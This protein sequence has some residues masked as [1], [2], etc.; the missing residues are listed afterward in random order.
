MQAL[1]TFELPQLLLKVIL[2]AAALLGILLVCV[3]LV[4]AVLRLLRVRG[5][6]EHPILLTNQGNA[7]SVYHLTVESQEPRLSFRFFMN[8]IPL[9]EVP[10]PA[11]TPPPPAAQPTPVE[12][13]APQ[14]GVP[15][16][17]ASQKSATPAASTAGSAAKNA[18]K[19]GQGVAKKTG[20]LASLLGALGGLLPGKAGQQLKER[21]NQAREMQTKT[22]Q[23]MEAPESAQRRM[24]AVQK[25][26][27]QLGVQTPA[28]SSPAAGGRSSAAASPIASASASAAANAP[29][30]GMSASRQSAVQAPAHAL[31][32]VYTAQTREVTPGETISLMLR[33]GNHQNFA[34]LQSCFCE[35][36][37]KR[38]QLI[39]IF[40]QQ[41][42]K[43]LI[44]T[45]QGVKIMVSFV[46]KN[47]RSLVELVSGIFNNW[48]VSGIGNLLGADILN[49][50]ESC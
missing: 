13:S 36:L 29:Q 6:R 24:D 46:N 19:A 12:Q 39:A 18:K 9:A 8:K 14:T 7:R 11:P 38:F 16:P 50:K 33:I 43:C 37:L 40:L 41:F 4:V 48:I 25:S 1:I 31:P 35:I 23:A 15:A 47:D 44:A 28:G 27:G 34:L 10:P 45:A 20:A 2:T 17:S 26:S 22:T 49:N 21:G 5:A 3:L 30:A 42:C 32:Y